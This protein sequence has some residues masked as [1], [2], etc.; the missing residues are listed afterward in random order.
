MNT[1]EINQSYT[2]N[3]NTLLNLA[4]VSAYIPSLSYYKFKKC[5]P[6]ADFKFIIKKFTDLKI[7][8]EFEYE[9]LGSNY[10]YS[11]IYVKLDSGEVLKIKDAEYWNYVI[12]HQLY[13]DLSENKYI[14]VE[15]M[16]NV[17]YS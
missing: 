11:I 3:I 5:S 4:T 15:I 10:Y 17:V 14:I 16:A 2:I 1:Y 7:S 9:Y 13:N 8:K 6:Y 12:L